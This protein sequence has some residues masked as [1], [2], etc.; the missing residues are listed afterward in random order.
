MACTQRGDVLKHTTRWL[1]TVRNNV[2]QQLSV[3]PSEQFV[4][5]ASANGVACEI[6][7]AAELHGATGRIHAR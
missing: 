5:Q 4:S 3:F 1:R 2:F 7:E 6:S